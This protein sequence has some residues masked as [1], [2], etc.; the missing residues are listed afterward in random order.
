M[1]GFNIKISDENK[2]GIDNYTSSQP[3]IVF[4]P[5]A[6]DPNRQI[7]WY[8]GADHNRE[9]A[10]KNRWLLE[11][12]RNTDS[13]GS[14]A[15]D[16]FM[17]YAYKCGRP[18]VEIEEAVIHHGQDEIYVPGKTKWQPIEFGFYERLE[19]AS[20]NISGNNETAK[21]FF[22]WWA[23]DMI[24]I[25]RSEY[26]EDKL[27]Y[28][29]RVNIFLLDGVGAKSHYYSLFDAWPTKV[30]PSELD[31]TDSNLSE[32]SVTMRYSKAVEGYYNTKEFYGDK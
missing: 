25:R 2:C 23:N 4:D 12:N 28:L 24:K 32:I 16:N 7:P 21:Y 18:S 3:S 20:D 6:E 9:Y 5:I 11:I 17:I 10:R 1:P 26:N 29:L 15:A 22:T 14:K 8:K 19:T 13:S 31:Y 27:K 30:S